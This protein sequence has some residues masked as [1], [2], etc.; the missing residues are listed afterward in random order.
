MVEDEELV[1]K[2]WI[3]MYNAA[4]SFKSSHGTLNDLRM[5]VS[6]YEWG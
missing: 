5:P 6:L 1:G 4:M 2:K 3:D